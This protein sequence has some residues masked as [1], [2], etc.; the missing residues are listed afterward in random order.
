MIKL[1]KGL[2]ELYQRFFIS[3]MPTFFRRF[4]KVAVF[5]AAAPEVASFIAWL[6]A[7][8]DN[9]PPWL[10]PENL[11]YLQAFCAGI[12]WTAKFTTHWG[13]T[14]LN[15]IPDVTPSVD[16]IITDIRPEQEGEIN[17]GQPLY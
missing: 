14:D 3:V 9:L 7:H 10:K 8:P 15:K 13:K 4:A 12:V 17:N 2:R 6:L 16:V 11:R 1:G 5:I